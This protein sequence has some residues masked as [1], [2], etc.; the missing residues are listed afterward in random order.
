MKP[1]YTPNPTANTTHVVYDELTAGHL[2]WASAPG[3]SCADVEAA[4]K[5]QFVTDYLVVTEFVEVES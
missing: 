3:M 1:T 4:Y 2:V 5:A